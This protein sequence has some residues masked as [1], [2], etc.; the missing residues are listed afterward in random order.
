MMGGVYD[1]SSMPSAPSYSSVPTDAQCMAIGKLTY[2]AGV[3]VGMRWSS[4]GSGASL[5]SGMPALKEDFNYA[6]AVAITYYYNDDKWSLEEF[7]K[8]VIPNLDARWPVAFATSLKNGH[9]VLADGY[10]YSGSSFYIHVN[11][12]WGGTSDA[13]Y[14]PPDIAEFT[15]I[16]GVLCNVSPTKAGN[17]LSGRVADP[18]E[19]PISGATVSLLSGSSVLATTTTDENGIYA[20][21]STRTG[22]FTVKATSEGQTSSV[23][24]SL[25][26]TTPLDL[27][28]RYATFFSTSP[29]LCAIG[30][31]YGNDIVLGTAPTGQRSTLTLDAQGGV[32]GTSSVSVRYGYSLPSITIPTR[33]GYSFGGYW[34]EANGE[35]TQCYSRTGKGLIKWKKVIDTI[36]YAKWTPLPTDGSLYVD[37]AIGDDANNGNSWATAKASIQAAIGVAREGDLILVN[38]GSYEPISSG[39]KRLEIR[40]VNGAEYTIIDASLQWPRGVTNRCATLGQSSYPTNATLTGFSLINGIVNDS[41]G[42]GGAYYGTLNNCLLSGNSAYYYGGGASHGT[43]NNCVLNGNSAQYGGGSVGG[44]LNNCTLSGNSAS[45]GGGGA[46][47]GTLNNCT[48]SGNSAS[49]GGGSYFGTLNNCTLS[50]NSAASH[51]GGAC[52]GTLNN[53]VISGNEAGFCGGGADGDA[54]LKLDNCTITGNTAEYGGGSSG[55]TLNNCFILS[56]KARKDGGGSHVSTLNN[57]TLS[58][59]VAQ[60]I[61]GGAYGGTLNNCIVWGNTAQQGGNA[62]AA[63]TGISFTLRYCCVDDTGLSGTGNIFDNPLFADVG[64]GDFRLM[65]CSPCID[66]G[67]N[68]YAVG[69]YDITGNPRIIG[70]RIDI[71]AYEY[72]L[73]F[74]VTL[75]VDGGSGGTRSIKAAYDY[76]MPA[77]TV[78]TRRGYTFGGY[79]SARNGEGTQYYTSAGKSARTYSGT[80]LPGTLY[81]KWTAKEYTLTLDRQSGSGGTSSVTA[82]FGSAMPAISVPTRSNYVFGGYWTGKNGA[83]TQYY[84]DSGKSVREWDKTASTTLYAKWTYILHT[85]TFDAHG[86]TCDTETKT[87]RIG[88][89]YSDMPDA[90]RP[91]YMFAGWWTSLSTGIWVT[92]A[93]PIPDTP[94]STL[95]AM[96]MENATPPAEADLYVDASTGND[97]NDG[98]SWASAKASIQAAIDVAVAGETILVN[99]GRYEPI[100]SKEKHIAIWSVNGAESTFIDASLLWAQGVTN[101]CAYL[102]HR[103]GITNTVLT[104][105]CLANGRNGSVSGMVNNCIITGNSDSGAQ[106]STLNNCILKQNSDEWHGGGAYGC[107]LSNCV[108][109]GN[110]VTSKVSGAS[111]IG[112]GAYRS[113][114]RNCI[115]SGNSAKKGGGAYDSILNNCSLTGNTASNYG[116][117]ACGGALTNCILS[118]NSAY[119]GGGSSGGTLFNCVISGNKSGYQGG[120]ASGGTLTRCTLSGNSAYSGGGSYGGTLFNCVIS[121][122]EAGY[123]GGGALDSTMNNCLLIGNTAANSGGGAYGGTLGN[124]TLS[125]NTAAISGGGAYGGTLNNCIVWGNAAKNRQDTTDDVVALY[126]LSGDCLYGIGNIQANPEF[127]DSAN[128]DYRLEPDSPCIDAGWRP[129]CDP[130]E[131]DVWGMPRWQGLGLDMGAFEHDDDAYAPVGNDPRILHVDARNGDDANDGLA[132]ASSKASI[133]AAVKV[134]MDGGRILVAPGTYAP[135]ATMDLRIEIIATNGAGSVIIDADGQNRCATLGATTNTT[136]HGFTLRNGLA[137]DGGGSCYGTLKDC[138][139]VGNVATNGGGSYRSTLINCAL[140]GNKARTGGGS[141]YGTLN[142]CTLSRNSATY[143][144]GGSYGGTL[145]GCTISGNAAGLYGGGSSGGTLENCAIIDNSAK[146]YGGGANGGTLTRCTLSGNKAWC[147]GGSYYGTLNNCIIFDNTAIRSNVG[148]SESL[149]GGSYESELNNCTVVGNAASFGGGTYNGVVNNCIVWGNCA[150]LDYR[151]A[152]NS[153]CAYSCLEDEVAGEGNI[154]ADPKFVDAEKGDF[155]LQ[156]GSPCIDAGLS[157][158]AIG[159]A[160]YVGNIRVYGDSVD[161]GAYEYGSISISQV[162][163]LTLDSQNGNGESL[164]VTVTYGEAMPTIP[165]PTRTGYTFGGYWTEPDGSGTQYY[166]ASGA[167]ARNWNIAADTTL[168]AKWTVTKYTITFERQGGSGGS[169]S[170]QAAN[171]DALPSITPPTRPGCSFGGYWTAAGG[172]GTQYYS[173]SGTGLRNWDKTASAKLYAKWTAVPAATIPEAIDD[174]GLVFTTGGDVAWFGQSATSHDG[175]D[176]AQSGPITDRQSSWMETTVGGSGTI[177]FWWLVSSENKYDWLSLLVDG[178]TTNRISGT[179]GTWERVSLEI[180]GAGTHTLRWKYGKDSSVSSGNDSGWVDQIEWTPAPTYTV[181]Y[182]PGANGTGAQQTAT[183]T[184]DI[185]L[186]LKGAIF[187]RTGY[188]QTGWATSDGGAKVYDLGASYTANAAAT[189]YPVWTQSAMTIYADAATGDDASDGLSWATAKRS[190]QAAIDIACDGDGILVN[191]GRYEPINSNNKRIDIRSVNGADATIID[192][193]LQWS[194]GVTNRCATLGSSSSHTNTVLAGFCLTNGIASYGGG[195]YCGR[196]NGCTLSGNTATKNDGGGSFYGTLD[197]CTLSGNM[198]KKNGGGSYYGTLNNCT[199]SGNTAFQNGGGSYYGT[200]N[201]CTLNG[202]SATYGGG[203]VGGTLNNCILIGNSASNS[204][205]G[206]DYGTLNNCTLRG[207]SAF[208]DGGGSYYGVLNNCTL[209]GNAARYGGGSCHG[210]LNNCTLSGNA[211]TCGGGS[212]GGTLNN[213]IVW[214]NTAGNNPNI[215][216]SVSCVHTCSG[217]DIPGIGNICADPK[218]IDAENGDFHLSADS[219]CIDAGWRPW[220]GELGTDIDGNPRW[221]GA[222]IDMGAYES[223]GTQYLPESRPAMTWHVDAASGNDAND[224]ASSSSALQSIQTAIER[225]CDGDTILV[226]P[227]TYSP[228]ATMDLLIRIEAAGASAPTVIDGGGVTRCATFGTSTNTVLYGFGLVNGYADQCGGGSYYGT[229]V[230]CTL[231]GNSAYYDG[232]GSYYGVLNNCILSG[233]TVTYYNG[234]GGGS[235]HGTLNNCTL[236]GNSATCGGGSYYG[237]LNNC[238][239]SGNSATYGG[240]AYGGTLDNCTLSGNSARYDGG[241]SY[242]GTLNN[243][244]IWGNAAPTSNAVYRST[245]SYS[246]LDETVS[247]TG[248]IFTDPLFADPEKGDYSLQSTSPCIDTGANEYAA[249]DTDIM[250]NPRIINGTVDMGSYEFDPS[251]P[252]SNLE[253][254]LDN[255]LGWETG[256]EAEWSAVVD[257]NSVNGT[258]AR[259]GAIGDSELSWIETSINGFGTISFRWRVSSQ[260]RLD[261]L[262]FSI[263]GEAKSFIAGTAASVTN[264]TECSFDIEGD[265]THTLRWTYAK[266]PSGTAGEDCGWLDNVRWTPVSE[267]TFDYA[268]ALDAPNLAWANGGGEADAW[269]IVESPSFDGEDACAAFAKGAGGLARISTEVEGAGTISFRWRVE[270]GTS[271]AGIAFMV[272]GEDVEYCENDSWSLFEYS[273]SGE[274][275]HTFAWEYFWDG[276]PNGDAAFLDCVSWTPVENAAEDSVTVYGVTIPHSWLSSEAGTILVA[277]RGDYEAAALATAANGVNKVWECYVAGISP[278]NAA[279]LFRAVISMEN[280][281]PIIGWEPKLSAAEEAKRVYTVEGKAH[282]TDA[283]APTNSASRFFRVKVEME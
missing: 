48:L 99:D 176:A 183:K 252:T 91:G 70:N 52:M 19:A 115:L 151:G 11:M 102:G 265:G 149:G 110:Y 31:S 43:L 137:R 260:A 225:S 90:T 35:G 144:G 97:E 266:S 83:G 251:S 280:G 249:G 54:T 219:P 167:S 232:G 88:E 85:V 29:K 179:T 255:S 222:R 79:Y 169:A 150:H 160:D 24:G 177:S 248:N 161:I 188:T 247:G 203:T 126:S 198:A 165:V 154:V 125:R 216:R 175:A 18:L 190:I 181:T 196:L 231:S 1:W 235:N 42:G 49:C 238:T 267:D 12:G 210:T 16:D 159:V 17:I 209:S 246:C 13:W 41:N 199:L 202:N 4:E 211:A 73:V 139:I 128:G 60:N 119:Y 104:G 40:S 163:N 221:Q 220:N 155:R 223:E 245:C 138:L 153:T 124:C 269:E 253:S 282:L 242:Y 256:G 111:L 64:N 271:F 262:T 47:G 109:I 74:D 38:D 28:D 93:T 264:W 170:V 80:F 62:V 206:S 117:G 130:N 244:I 14:C 243:C 191:D 20:F 236:S 33:L 224:G 134:S 193:S 46:D 186:T 87:C 158:Y 105:F 145:T 59:N 184:Q 136:L 228:I 140:S 89:T 55:G 66:A 274:G 283:W 98:R 182:K 214:G 25:S 63:T 27:A 65:N 261:R 131:L 189:L 146:T 194:R 227:G 229:L 208:Y 276:T 32:G 277:N 116:G 257:E 78:P 120:G 171:G 147:G 26:A 234:E 157:G 76:A 101:D 200:L 3:S 237:T 270:G 258:C 156:S 132:W 240:G 45:S 173:A 23:S 100:N 133:Q 34:T 204:G 273:V 71:G 8:A 174:D 215:G 172:S 129:S 9:A 82:K 67:L 279:D 51:G 205:G 57:C 178:I 217:D 2:D 148:S 36:L 39:G 263:D 107:D 6:N 72:G 84:D 123:Q 164:S 180:S 37:A 168:Y 201:N 95:H 218:F 22:T 281:N 197:N 162:F 10:G 272:D 77:I 15:A 207:N 121:G 112:G 233:N 166:T 86:G 268:E 113:T 92:S 106:Y 61:G 5:Y 187:T 127:V 143:Q 75:D 259:S 7:K 275:T 103:D 241:G 142:N 239:L 96:W 94:S 152:Y 56:N 213:C 114:L 118:G 212:D 69:D 135:I 108:L 185:T 250:G 21:V 192:A 44:I 195:S 141:A 53:C 226:A 278:T 230:N 30:N 68:D 81:A 254:A 122:N 50:G 58:K